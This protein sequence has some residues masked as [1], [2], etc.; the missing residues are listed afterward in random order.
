MAFTSRAERA[1]SGSKFGSTPATVGPGSYGSYFHQ[2]VEHAYAPFSSTTDRDAGGAVRPSDFV[3]PGPGSY[4][5]TGRKYFGGPRFLSAPSEAGFLS[6]AARL[7]SIPSE[8]AA[9]PGPGAYQI[10]STFDVNTKQGHAGTSAAVGRTGVGRDDRHVV[11]FR[12]PTAPSIPKQDQAFGYEE[13]PAGQLV[14]QAAPV[15]RYKGDKR[16]MVGPGAYEVN[17]G[18]TRPNPR[19]FDFGRSKSSRTEFARG[20]LGGEDGAPG[21]GTYEAPTGGEVVEAPAPSRKRPTANFASRVLRPHQI[22]PKQ[23]VESKKPV[24]GPGAYSIP[25]SFQKVN[26]ALP[27]ALQCF[28]STSKRVLQLSHRD[29]LPGPGAYEDPRSSFQEGVGAGLGTR[30]QRRAAPFLSTGNRFSAQK[31][32]AGL[33]GPGAYDEGNRDNFVAQL[34]K[35]RFSRGGHFGS[36]QKRFIPADKAKETP[37]PPST[38]EAKQPKVMHGHLKKGPMS[39]FLS[40]T[41][42]F[43]KPPVETVGPAPG[44][45]YKS[46]EWGTGYRRPEKGGKS[47]FISQSA[48]FA[49]HSKDIPGPGSYSQDLMTVGGEVNKALKRRALNG[50]DMPSVYFG[51]ESRFFGA[52]GHSSYRGG[53]GLAPGPGSYDAVDPYGQLLKR[54]F[55]ITVEGSV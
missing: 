21:P 25:D 14:K 54:S 35:K 6:K 45:Y 36:T 40:N 20:R 33:P 29:R 23:A 4:D 47:F 46:V 31:M 2:E 24:P 19:G 39:I 28:G 55:N 44:Q 7:E 9:K 15:Q 51:T 18:S 30:V 52:P 1:T 42:R 37:P 43:N 26:K 48:R 32:K 10:Q 3:T 12:A 53:G 49:E 38:Y 50:E 11:W 22:S 41:Q 27:D 16:D 13:G 5:V 17:V 34:A 8:V